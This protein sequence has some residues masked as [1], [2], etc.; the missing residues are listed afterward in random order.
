MTFLSS[1]TYLESNYF[2][3]LLIVF[4]L[5]K[6]SVH[7]HT[8]FQ[9]KSTF[10]NVPYVY[11]FFA[12]R[13]KNR[14]CTVTYIHMK[15]RGH[16]GES[17]YFFIE[18]AYLSCLGWNGRGHECLIPPGTCLWPTEAC[19]QEWPYPVRFWGVRL[20]PCEIGLDPLFQLKRDSNTHL[21][22]HYLT[23]RRALMCVHQASRSD[24]IKIPDEQMVEEKTKRKVRRNVM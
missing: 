15:R 7:D 17:F 14:Y 11:V 23:Y 8:Y 4:C 24:T 9:N 22:S 3:S 13:G 2:Y 19:A 1:Y 20:I 12:C 10:V 21:I 5:N 6:I 18:G 16:N